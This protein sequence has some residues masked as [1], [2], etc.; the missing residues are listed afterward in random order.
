MHT[1]RHQYL[2]LAHT[3]TSEVLTRTNPAAMI[4]TGSVAGGEVDES[5]DLDILL[6]F[7][8]PLTQ[9]DWA[10]DV[11]L[12]GSRGGGL[13]H[14]NHEQGW[15]SYH[16]YDGIK[17]DFAWGPTSFYLNEVEQMYLNPHLK[18][19]SHLILGGLKKGIVLHGE[20]VVAP[21]QQRLAT[22][23]PTLAELMVAQ[24]VTFMPRWA[25]ENM[26]LRRG[27]VFFVA[28]HLYKAAESVVGIL[29]GLNRHFLP[30]K[31]KG[32]GPLLEQ[33]QIA[34]TDIRRRTEKLVAGDQAEAV[35]TLIPLVDEL[36]TLVQDHLP[37]VDLSRARARWEVTL[38]R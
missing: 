23:P 28:E 21:L 24:H 37:Q 1:L 30:G 15:A 29:C 13:H 3:I 11:A 22:F 5:S 27:D 20:D 34:P 31:L 14:G 10:A 25:L 8:R 17:V 7:N 18:W 12:A 32:C 6:W 35:A 16:F 36:H 19:D 33:M 9:E 38:R 26:G 4:L 2:S